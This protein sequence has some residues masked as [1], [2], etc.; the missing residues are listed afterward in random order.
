M[1]HGEVAAADAEIARFEGEIARFEVPSYFRWYGPLYRA[2]RAVMEGRLEEGERL[3]L[4]SFAHAQRVH[5]YDSPRAMAAQLFQIRSDQGRLEELDAPVREMTERYPDDLSFVPLHAYVLAETDRAD[6][7]RPLFER[8]V[9]GY[10]P[11]RD[12][13]RTVT[14]TILA[15]V[16]EA[17]G[18][19]ERAARLYDGLA[20]DAEGVTVNLSAWIC[21]G[22]LHWPLGK[23]AATRGDPGAAER[24]LAEAER[25]NEALGARPF[26][27]RTRLDRARLRAAAGSRREAR[28]L[29]RAALGAAREIGMARLASQAEGLLGRLGR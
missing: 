3:A 17:L 20:P 25:R 27:A 19:G 14:G 23:L 7:A 16:C 15:S 8:F 2:M 12:Q 6:A 10:D 13:N 28:E 29:A 22:S 24:H 26:L 18:D 11:G 9:D 1:E 5:V 21:Q 4:D